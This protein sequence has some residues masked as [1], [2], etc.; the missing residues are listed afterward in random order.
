M[1]RS[2]MGLFLLALS[3][4]ILA[5]AAGTIRDALKERLTDAGAPT[6]ARERV[7]AVHVVSASETTVTPR[8]EAFGEIRSRRTLDLRTPVGGTIIAMSA[9]FIEGGTVTSGESLI[10]FDPANA[11]TSVD[12]ARTDLSD[13]ET[14]LDDAKAAER[15]ASDE[16]EA[17]RNQALLRR[18]ALD[19][20]TDLSER[21]VGTEAAVETAALALAAAEQAILTRRQALAQAATRVSRAETAVARQRI[22][23]SEAERRLADTEIFAE[24]SGV[25]GAVNVVKGGLVGPNERIARLIDPAALEVSFRLS[26]TQ[27]ARLAAGGGAG[28]RGSVLVRLDVFGEDVVARGSIARVSAEVGQGQTGRQVFATLREGSGARFRP[29]DFV[30]VEVM[31]PPLEN[32]VVLPALA[33][34]SHDSVLVLGENHRLAEVAVRVLRAQGDEVI[35]RSPDIVGR[36]IVAA[37][38]PFLGA[39]IQVKPVRGDTTVPEE[40]DL[41][42]L[43]P[44]RRARLVAFVE[45]NENIPIDARTRILERLRQEKVPGRIVRRIESRIG[46]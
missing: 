1:Q 27:F 13:A 43:T 16:L 36:E 10:S 14:E 24:F 45:D 26:N 30:T 20:Q 9:N 12:V 41:I 6:P 40:P 4:G 37:R 11:Q 7:F 38:S 2:I 35:V 33:V 31:E 28:L 32:V 42:A 39:G 23:L 8:I 44:E 19:R 18:S 29:G 15:L 3:V 46:G 34:G 21:G 22:R 17:A 25:L 5:L